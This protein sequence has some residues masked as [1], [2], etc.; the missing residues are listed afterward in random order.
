MARQRNQNIT[1]LI[2]SHSN[3]ADRMWIN[4]EEAFKT[5]KINTVVQLGWVWSSKPEAL[6]F[7]F[8]TVTL[9]PDQSG[10]KRSETTPKVE[11]VRWRL[12]CLRP[13]P[14]PHPLLKTPKYIK[15]KTTVPSLVVLLVLVLL[16]LV[17]GG[18]GVPGQS[19][20]IEGDDHL[21]TLDVGLLG[22]HQVRLVRVFPEQRGRK[23]Q[24]LA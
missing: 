21:R 4:T 18:I 15:L 5:L 9:H 24:S 1:S 22:R 13:R 16:L 20:F 23:P 12:A 6:F 14:D 3:M 17:F 2:Q 7:F 8:N 10:I 11:W 19:L